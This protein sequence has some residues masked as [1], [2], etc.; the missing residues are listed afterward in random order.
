MG[1]SLYEMRLQGIMAVVFI[2]LH[3]DVYLINTTTM[4]FYRRGNE[5][6][7]KSG[8]FSLW[9]CFESRFGTAFKISQASSVILLCSRFDYGSTANITM[10]YW[11]G[12]CLCKASVDLW[13]I[14]KH[15]C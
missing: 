2:T 10:Y 1:H 13:K 11:I 6:L 4:I 12:L 14:M 9:V 15:S 5:P 3:L 7:D 8:F